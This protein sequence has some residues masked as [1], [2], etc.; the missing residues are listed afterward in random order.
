MGNQTGGIGEAFVA[1][2]LKKQGYQILAQNYR[3]R[4][5]EIDIVAANKIFITFVEVKTRRQDG[6]TNPYEAVTR[7]K[8]QKIKLAAQQYL[9]VYPTLL[10]PRFDVAAVYTDKMQVVKTEILENAF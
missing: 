9:L 1:K 10:Q 7:G 6:L 8:Q 4:F 5:G 3:T 2:Q